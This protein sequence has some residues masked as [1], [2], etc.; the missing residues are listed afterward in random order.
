M[1]TFRTVDEST[2][3][4]RMTAL[5]RLGYAFGVCRAAATIPAALFAFATAVPSYAAV[6]TA[7]ADR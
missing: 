2:M 7:I 1:G 6:P 5:S 4:S 3:I